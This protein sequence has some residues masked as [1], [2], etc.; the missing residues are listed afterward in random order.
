MSFACSNPGCTMAF[1]Y[2]QGR[3]F[4]FHN[5]SPDVQGPD[6]VVCCVRHFWLCDGC[7]RTYVLEGHLG[8]GVV[9]RARHS[10]FPDAAV[11]AVCSC[12]MARLSACLTE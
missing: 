5:N 8:L 9:V 1:D 11:R 6:T 12:P 4:R 7:S 10:T 2:R 3:L